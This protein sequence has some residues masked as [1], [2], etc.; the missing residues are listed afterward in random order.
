ATGNPREAHSRIHSSARCSQET[1]TQ[2]KVWIPLQSGPKH[3]L[4]DSC[5]RGHGEFVAVG[6]LPGNDGIAQN[7]DL[8]DLAFDDVSGLQVPRFRIR[9]ERRN[10][11]HGAG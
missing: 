7:A 3:R 5:W 11:G 6:F 10:P 4:L 2:I 9:A 8:L 1:W